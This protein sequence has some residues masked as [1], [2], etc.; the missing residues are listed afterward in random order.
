[1][2]VA[3]TSVRQACLSESL[4]GYRNPPQGWRSAI[5]R[6]AQ[7]RIDSLRAL[8]HCMQTDLDAAGTDDNGSRE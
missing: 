6:L 1:M 5:I 7:T 8:I 2:G 4:E 3:T